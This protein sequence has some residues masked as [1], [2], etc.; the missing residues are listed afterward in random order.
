MKILKNSLQFRKEQLWPSYMKSSKSE[1]MYVTSLSKGSS[2]P[3]KNPERIRTP[4]KKIKKDPYPHKILTE[5]VRG[6]KNVRPLRFN[7]NII[8]VIRRN[9]TFSYYF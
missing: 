6:I 4:H 1:N 2:P 3:L 9:L 8:H 5:Q 7:D